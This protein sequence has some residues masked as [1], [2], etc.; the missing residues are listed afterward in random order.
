MS[1]REQSLWNFTYYITKESLLLS[2]VNK[3]VMCQHCLW[4]KTLSYK[5]KIDMLVC[6]KVSI[7]YKK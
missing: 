1:S 4:E 7:I 2:K 5:I 6:D 3:L